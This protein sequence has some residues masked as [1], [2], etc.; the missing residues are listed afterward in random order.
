V[1]VVDLTQSLPGFENSMVLTRAAS[2]IQFRVIDGDEYRH[3]RETSKAGCYHYKRCPVTFELARFLQDPAA[4]ADVLT[5][6]L[7]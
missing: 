5:G 2:L 7:R 6:Y 4:Y 3:T 1:P